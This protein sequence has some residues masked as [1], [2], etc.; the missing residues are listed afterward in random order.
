MESFISL[1]PETPEGW[2]FH[3][4]VGLTS[5]RILTEKLRIWMKI[6]EMA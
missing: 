1:Q 4:N 2:G 3:H 6:E 5:I